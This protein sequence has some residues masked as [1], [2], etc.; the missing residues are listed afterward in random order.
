MLNVLPIYIVTDKIQNK[1][2]M[3]DLVEDSV[4]NSIIDQLD[5]P[6]VVNHWSITPVSIIQFPELGQLK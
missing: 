3:I 2:Y 4:N 5:I 1:V 6:E